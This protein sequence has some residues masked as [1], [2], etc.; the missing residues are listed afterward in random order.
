MI[1]KILLGIGV[2]IVGVLIAAAFKSPEMKVSR[3]IKIASTP[4]EIFPYIN[5]AEKSYEWMPWAEGDPGIKISFSGPQEGVGATSS[6]NGE[7]MGV[8]HSEVVESIPDQ[9][10]RTRL[11]YKEPMEMSQMAELSLKQEGEN[12]KVVWSVT[13]ESNYFFRLISLFIS[14]EEM[15]G[16]EFDKGLNK[17][18]TL[19]ENQ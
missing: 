14:C 4:K 17:L 6:W 3:E 1:K 2:V 8:G 18:K 7:K 11:V 12:T 16:P 15:I 19:V 10:V 9:L 5:S 13:G